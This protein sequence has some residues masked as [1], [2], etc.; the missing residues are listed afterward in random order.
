MAKATFQWTLEMHLIVLLNNIVYLLTVAFHVHDLLYLFFGPFDIVEQV[1]EHTLMIPSG[2]NLQHR[3][4]ILL[5]HS[6]QQMRIRFL[7][8]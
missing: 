2:C 5:I 3:L 4:L 1:F 6:A 7:M 8:Q